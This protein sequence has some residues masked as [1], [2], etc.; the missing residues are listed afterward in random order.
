MAVFHLSEAVFH[1]LVVLE[2]ALH[3][4][5]SETTLVDNK[6]TEATAE[7]IMTVATEAEASAEVIEEDLVEVITEDIDIMDKM[8]DFYYI[9]KN[10]AHKNNS[11][12]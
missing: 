9:L 5:D 8:L 11:S 7:V 1:L 2:V 6:D 4:V 3:L 10:T 12:L